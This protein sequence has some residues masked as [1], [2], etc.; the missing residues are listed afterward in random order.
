MMPAVAP[1]ER[2]GRPLIPAA[3]LLVG[4]ASYGDVAIPV[5]LIVFVAETEVESGFGH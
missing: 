5:G 3:A 1:E 4:A 2:P